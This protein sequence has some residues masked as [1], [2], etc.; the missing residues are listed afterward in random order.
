MVTGKKRGALHR[1]PTAAAH[2]LL[3]EPTRTLRRYP[4]PGTF[5]VSGL[6]GFVVSI[7]Y[8]ASGRFELWF[9]D[10]GLSLGVAFMI[11]FMIMFIA[12]L[13]SIT[14]SADE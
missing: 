9:G 10:L 1:K 12:A 5:M 11:V 3:T 4:L 14:P 7:I 2:A 13:F 8:T 6:V